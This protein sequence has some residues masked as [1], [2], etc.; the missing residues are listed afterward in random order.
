M[1][2]VTE[3]LALARNICLSLSAIT[4]LTFGVII[5]IGD[6]DTRALC[7][8]GRYA[9]GVVPNVASPHIELSADGVPGQ[10][11]LD[12]GSTRSSLS[13]SAFAASE[14]SVRKATI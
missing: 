5:E 12:Y 3:H 11:L 8:G 14:G 9:M 10:F 6:H 4:I 1:A 2:I 13:A 7:G